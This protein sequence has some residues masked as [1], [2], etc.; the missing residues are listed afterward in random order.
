ME[1][2]KVKIELEFD[3]AMKK[4]TTTANMSNEEMAGWF[5]K[6]LAEQFKEMSNIDNVT[7]KA[8]IADKE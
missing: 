5:E 1:V 2:K 4:D 6:W 3:I 7:V 8:A